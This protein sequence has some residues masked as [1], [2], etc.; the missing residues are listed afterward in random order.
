MTAAAG[1]ADGVEGE[2]RRLGLHVV[3]VGRSV[4]PASSIARRTPAA[5]FST[6]AGARSP[7]AVIGSLIAMPT[8]SR[9]PVV[10]GAPM[11]GEPEMV[12]RG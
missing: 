2:Q 6:I 11:A 9:W 10:T 8:D 7:P 3:H 4:I 1:V 5:T 12:M